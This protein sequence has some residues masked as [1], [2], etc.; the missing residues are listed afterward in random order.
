MNM[1]SLVKWFLYQML[2]E[3]KIA[4]MVDCKDFRKNIIRLEWEHKMRTMQIEDL[5][6]KARDL[7]MLPLT[8]EQQDVSVMRSLTSSHGH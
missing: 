3:Q 4:S 6:N 8:E 2:A 1:F 7:Q 5:N